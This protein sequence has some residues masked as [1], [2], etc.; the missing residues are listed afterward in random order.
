MDRQALIKKLED[1]YWEL[2]NRIY[3]AEKELCKLNPNLSMEQ[4]GMLRLQVDCMRDYSEVLIS[5]IVNLQNGEENWNE[6]IKTIE[7]LK[8]IEDIKGTQL[9]IG[10]IDLFTAISDSK[11]TLIDDYFIYDHYELEEVLYDLTSALL[12]KLELIIKRNDKGKSLM[13][14]YNIWDEEYTNL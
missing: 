11:E 10:L 5:R 7:I 8:D 4:R 13:E 12:D 6:L 3:K 14:L 9:D 1:E 2:S